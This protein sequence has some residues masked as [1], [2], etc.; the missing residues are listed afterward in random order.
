MK[1]KSPGRRVH[2]GNFLIDELNKPTPRLV[3][4]LRR[5][6]EKEVSQDSPSGDLTFYYDQ[7][8]SLLEKENKNNG[9][10]AVRVTCVVNTNVRSVAYWMKIQDRIQKMKFQ[11]WVLIPPATNTITQQKDTWE[12]LP[13]TQV[14][15]E[16]LGKLDALFKNPMP[17][18]S[19]PGSVKQFTK[20]SYI[21]EA[22]I[23]SNGKPE[24]SW[25]IRSNHY[26]KDF[27]SFCEAYPSLI[28]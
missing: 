23:A 24:Y 8:D 21:I 7:I 6:N 12:K 26:T 20:I 9:V 2:Q 28:D 18:T 3:E 5:I 4:L 10:Q 11:K 17:P 14:N 15:I 16:D 13:N 27:D 19:I 25:A 1:S 22:V